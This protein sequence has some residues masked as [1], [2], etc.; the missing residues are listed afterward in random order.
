MV[1]DDAQH[2]FFRLGLTSMSCSD[3]H[4]QLMNA[5]LLRQGDCAVG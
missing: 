3:G 1:A 2:K 4:V 5:A